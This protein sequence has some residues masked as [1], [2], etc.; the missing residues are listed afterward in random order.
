[1]LTIVLSG[2]ALLYLHIILLVEESNFIEAKVSACSG[3]DELA[4]SGA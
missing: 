3:V 4:N 1:M 2:K